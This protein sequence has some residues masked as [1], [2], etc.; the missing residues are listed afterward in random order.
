MNIGDILYPK[1]KETPKSWCGKLLWK[2]EKCSHNLKHF[3]LRNKYSVELL[4]I[5]LYLMEQAIFVYAIYSSKDSLKTTTYFVLILLSTMAIEKIIME[6]RYST[7]KEYVVMKVSELTNKPSILSDEIAEIR[8]QI[9]ENK[10]GKKS[11]DR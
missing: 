1:R 11:K 3:S 8:K 9:I 7:L 6:L 10:K 2:L 5:F 4:F